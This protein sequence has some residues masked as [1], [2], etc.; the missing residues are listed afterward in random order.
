[1]E[2]K[3]GFSEPRVIASTTG[4]MPGM[5]NDDLTFKFE[6]KNVHVTDRAEIDKMLADLDLCVADFKKAAKKLL[7][8]AE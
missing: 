4:L 3:C 5:F 6:A 1:M 7:K 2:T 8:T